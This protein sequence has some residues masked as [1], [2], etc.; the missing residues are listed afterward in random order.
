MAKMQEK[1]NINKLA[2]YTKVENHKET[3]KSQNELDLYDWK[4]W[5]MEFNGE[6]LGKDKY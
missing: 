3:G 2:D 6:S 1:V 4:N 5:E